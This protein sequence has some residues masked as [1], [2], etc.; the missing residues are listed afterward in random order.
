MAGRYVPEL[1]SLHV[2]PGLVALL[3]FYFL[4]AYALIAGMMTAV[5]AIMPDQQQGQ[6]IAGLLNLMFF[7]PYLLAA[8]FFANPNG[9]LAV[10]MTL[11]P[12]TAFTAITLR[13]GMTT[14]P[15][16]Q[17]AASW[18]ILVVSAAF[19]IVFAAQIFR[20]GML[21]YG[22]RLDMRSIRAALGGKGS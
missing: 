5:G 13:W 16:W 21:T 10:A 18:I 22:Q 7:V 15:L 8:A 2:S 11:F 14:I 4:P 6:Q 19:C 17:L 3:L 9:P 1:R 12:T 20:V